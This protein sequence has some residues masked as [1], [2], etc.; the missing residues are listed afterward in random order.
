MLMAKPET[1][2]GFARTTDEFSD[3]YTDDVTAEELLETLGK[4]SASSSHG[5]SQSEFSLKRSHQVFS[6]DPE[7]VLINIVI[8][9]GS[10]LF[11]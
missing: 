5:H 9:P 6:E 8:F 11:L 7:W 2:Q 1:A 3:S 4:M 10:H